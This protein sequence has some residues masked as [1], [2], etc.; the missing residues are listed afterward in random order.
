M[1][2]SVGI[3]IALVHW[4]IGFEIHSVMKQLLHHDHT[5][6]A[7]AKNIAGLWHPCAYVYWGGSGK[8]E[9]ELKD[10][11]GF[12]NQKEAEDYALRLATH[13]INNRLQASQPL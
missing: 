6:I 11:N 12:T 13:W 5:I 1:I 4:L 2:S 7:G 8:H 10:E 3:A 9:I